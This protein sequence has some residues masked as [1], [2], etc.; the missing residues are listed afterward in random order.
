M[1]DIPINVTTDTTGAINISAPQNAFL[2]QYDNNVTRLVFDRPEEF[3]DAALSIRFQ[4]RVT[5]FSEQNIGADNEYVIPNALT[6]NRKEPLQIQIRYKWLDSSTRLSNILNCE[7][8]HSI[9]PGVS[10][11]VPLPNPIDTIYAKA[12]GSLA[13][14]ADVLSY[15]NLDGGMIGDIILPTSGGVTEEY[16]QEQAALA[17]EAANAYTDAMVGDIGAILDAINRTVIV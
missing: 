7:V 2:T 15:Y 5:I 13:V 1:I 4:N 6:Q 11:I 8:R 14:D 16:V 12:V 3:A 17:L 10:P 9:D